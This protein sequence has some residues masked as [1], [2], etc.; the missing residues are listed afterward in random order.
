MSHVSIIIPTYK[1]WKRLAKCIQALANQSYDKDL[2]EVIIVNNDPEDPSPPFAELPSNFIII[3]EQKP[4][5]YAARNAALEI[6]KGDII[7]FTDS[8]CIPDKDWIR[9]AVSHFRDNKDCDRIAG[10]I[11]VF[12]K[13][14]KPSAAE[15][16]D[17]LN[18][19]KQKTTVREKGT[20]V[21]ANLFCRKYLFDTVGYFDEKKMS[22]GDFEWGMRAQKAGFNIMY[23][24]D[25]LVNHPARNLSDLIKK[26]KRLAGG[27][28]KVTMRFRWTKAF[29]LFLRDTRPRLGDYRSIRKRGDFLNARQAFM[30]TLLRYR[31]Q[32]VRAFE[33]M[34]LRLG[35]T[36]NRE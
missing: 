30:V 33:T 16:Y 31:L 4:G 27:R 32:Y 17:R 3:S 6:A 21:T 20:C 7:G 28:E 23:A 22:Y 24:D 29:V 25:V 18:A 8:D 1:D 11:F 9:N 19:F 36:P 26:E 13:T 10:N 12:P 35:K 14:N 15:Q 34:K 5:S 2:Y